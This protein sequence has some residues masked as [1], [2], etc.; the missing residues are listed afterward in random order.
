[1]NEP[2]GI[3]SRMK[4][5]ERCTTTTTKTK[6]RNQGNINTNIE[7]WIQKIQYVCSVLGTI[8]RSFVRSFVS[9]IW[10]VRSVEYIISMYTEYRSIV[11]Q[12]WNEYAIAC[13]S[14]RYAIADVRLV[15]SVHVRISWFNL[16]SVCSLKNI[17]LMAS[18]MWLC[19]IFRIKYNIVYTH[20]R[21]TAHTRHSPYI[22]SYSQFS[23]Y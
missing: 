13:I 2:N 19:V 20:G 18:S 8:G 15:R 23:L 17:N 12:T 6:R 21:H 16:S 7:Y 4:G 1:M 5:N 9:F 11:P 14:Q 22:L 3:R 10:F